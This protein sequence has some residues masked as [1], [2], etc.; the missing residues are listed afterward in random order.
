MF[1]IC[2]SDGDYLEECAEQEICKVPNGIAR[3]NQCI[4]MLSKKDIDITTKILLSHYTEA[5]DLKDV[6]IIGCK[7]VPEAKPI[8]YTAEESMKIVQSRACLALM[9]TECQLKKAMGFI[10]FG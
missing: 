5:K 1:P 9:I 2:L 6:M 7:N 3:A 10:K 4:N 8:T